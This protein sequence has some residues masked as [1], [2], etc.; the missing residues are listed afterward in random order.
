MT[1]F[2]ICLHN[3]FEISNPVRFPD[4][5]KNAFSPKRPYIHNEGTILI[6]WVGHIPEGADLRIKNLDKV[7]FL[8]HNVE[9][10]SNDSRVG[11]GIVRIAKSNRPV[12]LSPL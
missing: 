8:P 12:I 5:L 9:V 1:I 4:N 6:S 2:P 3:L 7:N 11:L 10:P